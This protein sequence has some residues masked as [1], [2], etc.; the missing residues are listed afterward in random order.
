MSNF[1]DE[2]LGNTLALSGGPTLWPGWSQDHP[3]LEKKIIY[4]NLK[5][6]IY[7]PLK[8]IWDH[9]EFFYA[10]KIKF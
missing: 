3:D 4:N 5:F 10:N 6:Y 8:K 9:P 7:L 1:E 2:D